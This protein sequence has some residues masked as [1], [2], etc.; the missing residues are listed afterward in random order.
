M[1]AT[2]HFVKL[3]FKAHSISDMANMAKN[4]SLD[5]SRALGK[6]PSLLFC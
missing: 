3:G 2:K 4:L 6:N 1:E 5:R